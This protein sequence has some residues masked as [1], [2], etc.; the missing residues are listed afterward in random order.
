MLCFAAKFLGERQMHFYSVHE[1]GRSKMV[2]AVHKLLDEADVL[3]HYN[4]TRFDIP[5]IN[6]ELL[7]AGLKPPSP[8]QQIDLCTIVQRRFRFISSKLEHVSVALGLKGKVSHEGFDLW[9][10]CMLGDEAAWKRMERYNKQDVRLLEELYEALQPWIPNHPHRGLFDEQV[11][12]CPNCGSKGLQRRGFAYTRVS[13][14]Q[15]FQ[16]K[17]CGA[18]TRSSQRD[19]GVKRV[20]VA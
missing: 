12:V 10:K 19:F 7:V 11:A 15:R 9:K 16:C 3:L 18:W 5:H 6:R 20:G 13:K 1:H 2:K 14:Y 4:G 17:D 8:Y